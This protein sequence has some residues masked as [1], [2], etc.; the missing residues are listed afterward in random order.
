MTVVGEV[1][2]PGNFALSSLSTVFTALYAAGGPTERGTFRSVKL[3]RN[4]KVVAE[5]DIYDFLVQG[6]RPND[7]TLQEGDVI[8][9]SLNQGQVEIE[10]EIKRPGFYEIKEGESFAELIQ[11]AGG[12]TSSAFKSFIT[13]NR[14]G[15]KERQIL[16]VSYDNLSNEQPKEGDALTVLPIQERFG[17]RVQVEGAVYLEGNFELVE[18]M[19]VKG[20]LEKADGLKGDAYMPRA[21]I[22]RV[23]ADF[24]QQTVAFDLQKLMAGEI[25]DI[26][27]QKE[28][29][30]RISSIYDL[31]EEYYVEI[32]G[33]VSD[34]GIYPFF[35]NMTIEDLVVLAG[36]LTEGA[37]G[38]KVEISRRNDSGS[39][40]TLS[41]IITLNF[42]K[43]LSLTT[44]NEQI[45]LEP[46]D[47]VFIR[48]TPNYTFQRKVTVEGEITNPGLYAISEKDERVSDLLKRAGGIT[49]Y[50]YPKGAILIRKTE[51]TERK[52]DSELSIEKL[53][54]LK[55]KVLNDTLSRQNEARKQ[56]ILRLERMITDGEDEFARDES[57]AN[58]LQK[59]LVEGIS[60]TDS[61]IRN[62][63]I[64]EQEPTV[65]DLQYILNNPG[66]KY[67]YVLREGDVVSI[68][69]KLETVRIA[70]EVISPVNLRFDESLRFKDYINDAGG[71]TVR[72]KKGRSYVQY[73][74]G[75][76]RQTKRFLF[77][78]FYPK[79][80]PGSTIIVS[81]KP[82]R[83]PLNIQSLVALAGSVATLG[84][85]A[86]QLSR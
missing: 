22:F 35:T 79:I 46:F 12:F 80:E 86:V 13:V 7:K 43:A 59:E 38:A 17:N 8:V 5:V 81:R 33:E 55:D 85:V 68:P 65:L 60:E 32:N 41:Q 6:I 30:V 83:T 14:A 56:L 69:S 23:N 19:T 28:D 18:G 76:R 77:F 11:S 63:E 20:L 16:N 36:G 74:N 4:N 34:Q 67:D 71:F 42:D 3:L 40:S 24:S 78:K 21:T 54:E 37:A 66:S 52:A 47:Q 29:I 26:Q 75:R 2:L 64:N 53:N 57:L 58:R 70:G 1:A 15:L 62:I 48:K 72:A 61:L 31:R 73:P 25:D 82:D 49:P 10:G 50:A 51:F 45:L 84:L 44:S 27:L 39:I 9:V